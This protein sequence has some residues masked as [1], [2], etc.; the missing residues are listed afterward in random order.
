MKKICISKDWRF[1]SPEHPEQ[2]NIDLPHDYSIGTTRNPK[3]AGGASNGFFEGTQGKYTKYMKFDNDEHVILDIDGAYMC[4][5]VFLNE[6]SSCRYR[7]C[8]T[9]YCYIIV[10]EPQGI[11]SRYRSRESRVN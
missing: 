3:S 6:N 1:S 7:I 8:R 4:A 2:I 11:R 10:T 5:R 9:F